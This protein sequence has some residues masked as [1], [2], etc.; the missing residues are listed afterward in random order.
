MRKI[1]I[2]P[3][4]IT[5]AN[6]FC[7]FYAITEAI[8]FEYVSAAWSILAAA[9]FDALDGRVARLAKATSK[10]GVEYDSLSDLVSFGIAPGI[11]LYQWAFAPYGRL[12]VLA[13]FLFATCGA[14]R[15]ARFNVTTASLPKGF[16]LGLPIPGAATAV[17]TLVI[18]HDAFG[19]FTL[20]SL[21][22]VA[23]SVFLSL[24]MVSTLRFPSFKEL[25]WKSR[26]TFVYLM[27]GVLIMVLMA[28]RPD[29][30]LFFV[31]ST[32]IS[33]T[34]LWN[35]FRLL[36]PGPARMVHKR[37]DGQSSKS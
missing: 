36:V 34:F 1:Y 6:L 9:V 32:Y 14:L 4:L 33:V 23:W 24:L 20:P 19:E 29:L 21:G 12:G 18:A 3:N 37:A 17:A 8:Q 13:A 27:I 15:L 35:V 31:I 30:T 11:L 26:A 25:N 7:G 2:V 5:T 28:V 22:V 16:F 10:F